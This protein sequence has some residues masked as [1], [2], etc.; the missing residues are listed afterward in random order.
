MTRRV[1]PCAAWS[2]TRRASAST[3]STRVARISS[4]ARA[5]GVRST[6]TRSST[7]WGTDAEPSGHGDVVVP[8][9]DVEGPRLVD[10]DTSNAV[11]GLGVDELPHGF[12]AM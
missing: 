1:I 3:A 9:V 11:F 6:P 12:V 4:A 5:A 10:A 8:R 7:Q 2:S